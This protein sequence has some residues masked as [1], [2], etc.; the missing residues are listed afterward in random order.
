MCSKSLVSRVMVTVQEFTSVFASSLVMDLQHVGAVIGYELYEFDQVVGLVHHLRGEPCDAPGLLHAPVDDPGQSGDVHV[1]AGDQGNGLERRVDLVEQV[2]C[3]AGGASAF[4]H[5]LRAFQQRHDG[6]RNLVLGDRH[7]IIHIAIHQVEGQVAR[8]KHVNA[9]CIGGAVLD[10]G[11]L[12]ARH[13]HEHGGDVMRLHADYPDVR[14]YGLYRHGDAADE[15][16]AANGHHDLLHVG[17]LLQN[18]QAKRALPRNHKR[19]VKGMGEREA[20][21]LGQPRG[22]RGGVVVVAR[23]QHHLAAVAPGGLHFEDG[24]A[25]RHADDGADAQTGRRQS[26]SLGMVSRRAGDNPPRR[27]LR[28]QIAHLVEGAAD[29]KGARLLQILGLEVQI[30]AHAGRGHDWGELHDPAHRLPCLAD[31]VQRY[32]LLHTTPHRS[33]YGSRILSALRHRRPYHQLRLHYP[34]IQ[35]VTSRRRSMC[36]SELR[37]STHITRVQYVLEVR[38]RGPKCGHKLASENL[39]GGRLVTHHAPYAT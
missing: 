8:G 25:F 1:A 22:L 19:V 9:V 10:G 12:A 28:R 37:D 31:H 6:C 17:H 30:L 34:P 16:A 32:L 3:H 23:N 20:L 21:F 27:L 7:D 11:Y 14:P 33:N 39:T 36:D 38:F 2:G 35:F 24:R 18:L 26:H 13:R 5:G 4:R 29:L 15:S